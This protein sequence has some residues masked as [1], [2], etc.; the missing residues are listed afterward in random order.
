M[1]RP[2][3]ICLERTQKKVQ[4]LRI[5]KPIQTYILYKNATSLFC[6]LYTKRKKKTLSVHETWYKYMKATINYCCLVLLQQFW[7]RQWAQD[8][9]LH[10]TGSLS[11]K[12]SPLPESIKVWSD[13][14]VKYHVCEL[15]LQES[16]WRKKARG[17]RCGN[18]LVGC[19][20]GRVKHSRQRLR[21]QWYLTQIKGS[22]GGGIT[23]NSEQLR[24][25][26][27]IHQSGDREQRSHGALLTL[28]L[29]ALEG[30]GLAVE[31]V[32]L[33][34]PKYQQRAHLHCQKLNSLNS[35]SFYLK[36]YFWLP[37]LGCSTFF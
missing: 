2:S 5:S 6:W 33:K 36:S 32:K 12:M 17:R 20:W 34:R 25:Q 22:Y 3:S 15:C 7:L 1:L 13:K 30:E 16:G 35:N 24:R 9:C 27:G 14:W 28:E 37:L 29:A 10:K 18:R 21:Q 4:N 26:S 23:G 19:G 11:H 8:V 31:E